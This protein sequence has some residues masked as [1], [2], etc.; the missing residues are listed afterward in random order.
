MTSTSDGRAPVSPT[1]TGV[2]PCP[3]CQSRTSPGQPTPAEPSA[4][5]APVE[6]PTQPRAF[7]VHF[8]HHGPQECTLHPDGRITSVMSGQTWRSAFTFDEM[9]ALDWAEARIEWDPAEEPELEPDP[10]PA[11]VE[12]EQQELFADEIAL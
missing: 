5:A 2:C 12:P 10:A 7:R 4:P 3:L 9:R 6:L 11:V 8:E 1:H